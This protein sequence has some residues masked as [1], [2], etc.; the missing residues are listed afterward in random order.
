MSRGA[1]RNIPKDQ[2]MHL[3]L[4][5]YELDIFESCMD[6]CFHQPEDGHT[7]NRNMLVTTMQKIHK[8]KEHLLDF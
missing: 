6:S 3:G 8:T 2:Q 7:S 4:W 5:T 1:K